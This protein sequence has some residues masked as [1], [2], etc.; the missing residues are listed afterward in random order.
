MI[1]IVK[2]L[3]KHGV[4]PV[5]EEDLDRWRQKFAENEKAALAE[6]AISGEISVEPLP[7]KVEGEHYLT[8]VKVGGD[9][10]TPTCEDLEKW[11]DV[12]EDAKG[13]P[14]FKIFTHHNVE[15]EVIHVGKI[16]D[17]E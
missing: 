13:D 17:V 14:D 11:R 3:P 7:E 5:S 16:I 1:T 6:G 8:V 2:V 9:D 12:F 15:V 4:A 10:Y